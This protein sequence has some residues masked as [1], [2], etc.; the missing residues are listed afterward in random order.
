MAD[1]NVNQSNIEKI[2]QYLQQNGESTKEVS[3]KEVES[4][5]NTMS[6]NGAEAVETEEFATTLA[7]TFLEREIEDIEDDYLAAWEDFAASDG[8]KG[9]LS[10]DDMKLVS[11]LLDAYKESKLPD[12]W[13]VEDGVVYDA[14]GK[15]V[16]AT[17]HKDLPEG[18]KI[19]DDGKILDSEGN[20]IGVVAE[21]EVY[22]PETGKY[23]TV[24]SFYTYPKEEATEKTEKPVSKADLPEGY[25][26]TDDGK[27]LDK[28]GKEIGRTEVSYE[29]ATSDGVND[30]VTQYFLY[31][32]KSELPEGWTEDEN[33]VIKDEN[34]RELSP[35]DAQTID[36]GN[37]DVKDGVIYN[38]FGQEVGRVVSQESDAIGEDGVP[39]TVA[40]YYL[41]ND[42]PEVKEVQIPPSELPEGYT[43]TDDGKILDKDG[44][45]F[46]CIKETYI[47]AANG[48]G[49][50]DKVTQYFKYEEVPAEETKLP[51]GWT[52]NEDGT[53]TDDKGNKLLPV[54]AE[55]IDNG[56]Y[57]VKDGKIYD[58]T[59]GN[60]V[61]RVVS[62]ETDAIDEEGEPVDET[63]D[64]YYLYQTETVEDPQPVAET[65]TT[66]ELPELEAGNEEGSEEKSVI[67]DEA[68][69][70]FAKQLYDTTAGRLGTDDEQFM[71]ILENPDLTSDDWVK[72]ISAYNESYGSFIQDVDADFSA[73]SGKEDIMTSITSKLLEAA[74]GGSEEAINLLAKEFH[75][76]TAGMT[77]TADEFISAFMNGASDDVLMAVMES[78]SE[79]NEGANIYDAVKKDFSGQI[80]DSYIARLNE[81]L[82][83]MRE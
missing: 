2:A 8:E 68:A 21:T 31:E 45:V 5:F 65:P 35:V 15:E 72:I 13:K 33:G 17:D 53:V 20:Q 57:E 74:E 62:Q 51:E 39:E 1:M 42:V 40:S 83:K 25:S 64:S 61:G 23:N 56:D 28:D 79:V 78:Y 22:D 11:D 41:Y 10:S 43:I 60:E 47:D 3:S 77:G 30:K 70:Q 6:G 54:D 29:D 50:N 75:N 26:I 12:D 73:M 38:E 34:G 76:G 14:S 32:E 81:I 4:V 46:G 55:V 48:D 67:T 59:T 58:K 16:V 71:D 82:A 80:E 44:N 66:E 7:E 52:E 18:H 69:A 63:V 24:E 49:V 27:I 36:E 37:Y 19:T 9:K